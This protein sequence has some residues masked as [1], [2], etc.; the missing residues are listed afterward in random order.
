MDADFPER[1]EQGA[2]APAQPKSPTPIGDNLPKMQNRK[3][4]RA[5]TAMLLKYT[6]G[7]K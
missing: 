4:R 6:K 3:Q 7:L 1:E 2:N 5:F